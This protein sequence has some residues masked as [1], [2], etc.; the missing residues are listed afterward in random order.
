MCEDKIET[1]NK[2]NIH[3]DEHFEEIQD[4][5]VKYILNGQ[6]TTPLKQIWLNM[7]KKL[8]N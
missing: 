4:L 2:F 1:Q 5:E 8:A 7:S 3:L 6:E